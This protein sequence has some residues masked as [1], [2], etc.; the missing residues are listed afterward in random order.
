MAISLKANRGLLVRRC[1]TTISYRR[2]WME[3]YRTDFLLTAPTS[4]SLKRYQHSCSVVYSRLS[5]LLK[6]AGIQRRSIPT[7][8]TSSLIKA[9]SLG[10]QVISQSWEFTRFL[11]WTFT[12]AG[13]NLDAASASYL[14]SCLVSIS[15][16]FRHFSSSRDSMHRKEEQ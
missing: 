2:N 4:F 8:S 12:R 5:Y 14:Q 3:V 11:C 7:D 10:G 15:H 9:G 13:Q 16:L 6:S 1:I